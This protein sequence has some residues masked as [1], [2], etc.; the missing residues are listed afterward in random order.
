MLIKKKT[1]DGVNGRYRGALS[2]P[3]VIPGVIMEVGPTM[4]S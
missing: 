3:K 4:R 1:R 2:N